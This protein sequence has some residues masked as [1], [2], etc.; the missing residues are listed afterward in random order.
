MA[1]V[2]MIVV[3]VMFVVSAFV[4]SCTFSGLR[5][6]IAFEGFSRTQRFA[7][8]AHRTRRAKF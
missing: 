1:F 3:V 6:K 7:F 5:L 2:A 8:Q 4:T